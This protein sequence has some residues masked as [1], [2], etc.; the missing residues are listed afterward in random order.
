MTQTTTDIGR[1]L[2]ERLN[3][4]MENA[5]N[6][7]YGHLFPNMAEGLVDFAYGRQF[8]R[9]ELPLRDR[10]LA[11]V[12]ALTALG[13]QTRPQLKVN[14]AGGRKADLTQKEIAEVFEAEGRND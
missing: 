7:R 12:A 5:L 3:P 4:G 1:E 8:A 2:S 13:S 11:T 14:I 6:E 10:Y 9:P